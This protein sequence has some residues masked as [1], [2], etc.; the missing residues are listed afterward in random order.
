MIPCRYIIGIDGGGTKTEGVLT[1]RAGHLLARCRKGSSN[2]NDRTPAVAAH[3][4]ADTIRELT[5]QSGVSLSD[6]SVWGGIS[7]ALN[8]R[9]TLITLLMDAFPEVGALDIGSDVTNLLSAELPVGDGACIICG[10][11]SACF[12]RQG[13]QYTRIGG[14]GYLLDSAGS[15]YDIGRMALEAV[16]RAHDG[17][18]QPTLLTGL[19][20]DRLGAGA[21]NR[22]TE[23]Y[24]GGKPLIASFAPSVFDAAAQGDPV[25]EIILDRNAYAIAEY[26]GAAY[27]K[28]TADVQPSGAP[29]PPVPMTV[30]L[31]GSISLHRCPE[32]QERIARLTDPSIPVCLRTA[33]H[34]VIWGAVVEAIRRAGN[35]AVTDYDAVRQVFL[36]S[37]NRD[38]TGY[39]T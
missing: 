38:M 24:A 13:Q 23:I 19:V 21:E 10:T 11:G 18:G 34:P 1:D 3:V 30:I 32:W 15:G 39:T 33:R 35:D 6:C 12:L 8:H 20:T 29:L 22:I 31:G 28:L 27:R 25:S 5:A 4:I 7:G 9:E 2:P 36:D 14:W 16:L 37:L 17:R 26:I